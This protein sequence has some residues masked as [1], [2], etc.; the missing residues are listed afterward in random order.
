LIGSSYL[1]IR[2]DRTKLN[3]QVDTV[4]DVKVVRVQEDRLVFQTLNPFTDAI[5]QLI[6]DGSKKLLLDLR[7]VQ[8]MDSASIGGLADLYRRSADVSGSLKLFGLQDRVERMV[9]LVGLHNL[10]DIFREEETALENF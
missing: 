6:A 1:S 9:S 5:A 3:L 4:G 10:I 7:R 2:G 8:Y